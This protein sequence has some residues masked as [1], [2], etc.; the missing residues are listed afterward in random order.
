[1]IAAILVAMLAAPSPE[2]CLVTR[3][4]QPA[5]AIEHGGKTYRMASEE[6]RAQFLSD[7]ERY[8]QLYDALRE[9]A[10]E[11]KPLKPPAPS[12]VPS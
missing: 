11:G 3:A 1:M 10:A 5:V 9:L 12:L 6:C 7:P 4:D 2:Q 8:S